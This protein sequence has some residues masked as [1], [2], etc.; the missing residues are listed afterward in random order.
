MVRTNTRRTRTFARS[1]IVT[2]A[3]PTGRT[4]EG[5]PGY[6]RDTRG[7]LFLAATTALA[8]ERTFYEPG[9]RDQRIADLVRAAAIHDP[10]WTGGFLRWLRRDAGF[11]TA[12]VI[13]GVEYGRARATARCDRAPG[14]TFTPLFIAPGGNQLCEYHRA[15]VGDLEGRYVPIPRAR[16]VLDSV[17][18]R[19]DEPGE[20]VAYWTATYGRKLPTWFRRGV[21][22]AAIRLWT[23]YAATKYDSPARAWRM[24]DVMELCHPGERRAGRQE[25]RAFQGSVDGGARGPGLF[26]WLI[27]DRHGRPDA[28]MPGPELPM[29]RARAEL[30]AIPVDGRR[31]V[32]A[33]PER[34]AVA[35]VTWEWLA[36][37]LQGPMDADAWSAIVPTMGHM[38]LIRN[39]RNFDV[40]GL[41]DHIAEEVGRRI[42]DPAAVAAGR[43]FPWAYLLAYLEAPSDRWKWAL[44]KALDASLGNIPAPRGRT[45][46]FVDLS[47]SM[48]D[49][50]SDKSTARR[51]DA[52]ALFAFAYARATGAE[53]FGF[54]T[55]SGSIQ[56]RPGV[57][58]LAATAELAG[59]TRSLFGTGTNTCSAIHAHFRPERHDRAIVFTDDQSRDGDPGKVMPADRP[60]YV[61]DLGG[62]YYGAA[63]AVGGNRHLFGGFTA[64]A[65]RLV[66]LL[67]SGRDAA[68]PWEN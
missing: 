63:H 2:E 33:D 44:T 32:L 31:A 24:A 30:A 38:A 15:R 22:D 28:A 54:A 16:A 20:A 50:L 34:L 5:A 13:L 37:W 55:G 36:G 27:A 19:A 17:L 62:Y 11:R 52:A 12:S 48:E 29:L 61:W 39:L 53:V 1:P 58:V 7:A 51:V 9:G 14:C 68:W 35:G 47:G 25:V 3:T 8:G 18:H 57:S 45:A 65:F 60:L 56:I 41:P 40:A 10:V 46:V 21:S 66:P 23:E 4:G 67:E 64:D 59:Q 49:R 6:A 26:P 42:A 43:Q